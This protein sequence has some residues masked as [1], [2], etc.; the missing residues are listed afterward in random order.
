MIITR[1]RAHG[2]IPLVDGGGDNPN[3]RKV[4]RRS[5]TDR[6]IKKQSEER[7]LKTPGTVNS[8]DRV[9]ARV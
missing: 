7:N 8:A 5:E 1:A 9:N 3:S 2:V 6:M 4:E